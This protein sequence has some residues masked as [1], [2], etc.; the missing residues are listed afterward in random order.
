MIIPNIWKVIEAMFQTTN[1][2]FIEDQIHQTGN[3][4]TW[5]LPQ[6]DGHSQPE[7]AL[8]Q[9]PMELQYATISPI[10]NRCKMLQNDTAVTCYN[11][12]ECLWNW[13]LGCL[14]VC[15]HKPHN[16]SQGPKG[17]SQS[18][19]TFPKGFSSGTV[20]YFN[21]S[22][23]AGNWNIAIERGPIINDSPVKPHNFQ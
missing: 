23:S 13:S 2:L 10:K 4:G 7:D 12:K 5:A 14:D 11:W 19:T 9:L 8:W 17:V 16:S 20:G 22:I 3:L 18:P 21:A 15:I 1:Q 6:A